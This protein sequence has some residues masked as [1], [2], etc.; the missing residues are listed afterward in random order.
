MSITAALVLYS[1]IWFLTFFV[2]LQLT[3]HT[4]ADA[5]EVVPGTPASAPAEET[6]KR[7][8]KIATLFA[9][10][11]F[12]VVAGVILSGWITVRDFD[13]FDRMG[14]EPATTDQP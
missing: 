2:V 9:T 10:A 5:G 12:A 4:Q 6:V 13:V 11:I 8:A 1:V 7:K 14:P 3:A